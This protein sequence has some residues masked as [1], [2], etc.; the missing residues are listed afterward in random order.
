MATYYDYLRDRILAAQP[1][2]PAYLEQLIHD[3]RNA[4]WQQIVANPAYDEQGR[5]HALAGFDEAASRILA[6]QSTWFD[7]QQPRD[8]PNILSRAQKPSL[9]PQRHGTHQSG[10][11]HGE[12]FPTEA[13]GRGRSL[14]R[15]GLLLLAG[16]VLG[17][18][19]GYMMSGSASGL[20]SSKTADNELG[21]IGLKDASP[22]SFRFIRS[23]P[24]PLEGEME[25]EYASG[26]DA[27][28]YDCTV[29]ATFR[30]VLEYVRFEDSCR[31]VAFKFLPLTKLWDEFNYVEGYM[32]FSAV[33][34]SP[35][36]AKWEGSNS[37]FF[38]INAEVS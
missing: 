4:L 5:L 30:Q 14:L 12:H 20:L 38:K 18:L 17:F 37:V 7:R 32:V 27:S 33:I 21:V 11:Q 23:D 29:D 2:D 34:T 6:E 9:P 26:A 22:K 28:N 3:E 19:L 8:V 10:H 16:I 25:V 35:T 15:D 1:G 31:R 36:G 13:P 24:S